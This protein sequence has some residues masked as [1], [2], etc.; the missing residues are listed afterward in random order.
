MLILVLI[1]LGHVH[2]ILMHVLLLL[3]RMLLSRLELETY[4]LAHMLV[5][6]P[7]LRFVLCYTL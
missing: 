6:P 7:T 2:V 3:V 1:L 5:L 4:V